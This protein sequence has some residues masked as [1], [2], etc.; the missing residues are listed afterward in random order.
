MNFIYF[1]IRFNH[2][3]LR[4]NSFSPDPELDRVDIWSFSN[5]IVLM[6]QSL[7][8]FIPT[9]FIYTLPLWLIIIGTLNLLTWQL[10]RLTRVKLTWKQVGHTLKR[11]PHSPKPQLLESKHDWWQFRI[12]V[13]HGGQLY[14]SNLPTQPK[15]NRSLQRLIY[16]SC[17]NPNWLPPFAPKFFQASSRIISPSFLITKKERGKKT[18]LLQHRIVKV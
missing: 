7:L 12:F 14:S 13:Q 4:F 17:W 6:F 9:F 5:N 11:P 18:P 3:R 8:I 15:I 16:V 1:F 2:Y 10:H